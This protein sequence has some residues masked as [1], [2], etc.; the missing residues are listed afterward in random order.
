MTK[1]VDRL[2]STKEELTELFQHA[3]SSG[4][5]PMFTVTH[6]T[7]DYGD[8]YT[9]RLTVIQAQSTSSE[10]QIILQEPTVAIADS[11]VELRNLMPDCCTI[12]NRAVNDD[13][14]IIEVW[15]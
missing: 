8:K 15:L 4:T 3:T 11:L 9:A 10:Q 1:D 14:V 7:S 6:G 2:I 12:I 5:L 13:P